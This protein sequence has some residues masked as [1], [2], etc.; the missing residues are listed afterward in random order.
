[1]KMI[2]IYKI[3]WKVFQ[4]YY[5]ETS[6]APKCNC[7]SLF[8]INRGGEHFAHIRIKIYKHNIAKLKLE[9][10]VCEIWSLV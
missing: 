5:F 8:N 6:F 2:E 1:M 7:R 3:S 10:A 4:T 9:A